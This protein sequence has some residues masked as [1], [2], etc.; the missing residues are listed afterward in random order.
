MYS[1]MWRRVVRKKL[2]DV[3]VEGTASIFRFEGQDKQVEY[4]W[5]ENRLMSKIIHHVA[6]LSLRNLLKRK[7]EFVHVV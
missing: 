6:R 3:S 5:S 2:T 1:V 7:G 4:Q